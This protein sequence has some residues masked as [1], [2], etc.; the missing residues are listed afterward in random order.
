[1]VFGV[2]SSATETVAGSPA[3]VAAPVAS[4]LVDEPPP[5]AASRATMTMSSAPKPS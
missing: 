2:Q 4:L 5:Q 3:D 1:L